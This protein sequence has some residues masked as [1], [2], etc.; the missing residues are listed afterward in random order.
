[1]TNTI[2]TTKVFLNTW[3]AYLPKK[4]QV[5]LAE[6]IHDAVGKCYF[7]PNSLIAIVLI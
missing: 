1:M 7:A 5:F 6:L 2:E 3:G 4:G